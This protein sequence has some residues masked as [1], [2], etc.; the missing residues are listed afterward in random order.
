MASPFE[1]LFVV[2]LA[3]E[4]VERLIDVSIMQCKCISLTECHVL[5]GLT[6]GFFEDDSIGSDV[7]SAVAAGP[8]K[9][10]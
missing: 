7:G 5:P 9:F 2:V 4:S 8:S 6:S 1:H 10:A 3:A